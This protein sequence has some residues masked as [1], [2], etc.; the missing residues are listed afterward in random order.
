MYAKRTNT[1]RYNE[2]KMND[3]NLIFKDLLNK[4][5]T[6]TEQVIQYFTDNNIVVSK[7]NLLEYLA[8]N[9]KGFY[10]LRD[11][12]ASIMAGISTM[13]SPKKLINLNSNIGE[14]LKYCSNIDSVEGVDSNADNVRLSKYFH[15]NLNFTLEDPL[16]YNTTNKFDSV[17]SYPLLGEHVVING[18]KEKSEELY[19]LKALELLEINGSAVIL[20][21]DSV[22]SIISYKHLRELILD[23]YGLKS[24]ISLPNGIFT[25]TSFPFSIIE[26]V[27][28][29]QT[30]THFYKYNSSIDLLSQINVK[31]SSFS[32][33]SKNLTERW[34]YH[35]HN[36]LN[37]KYEKQLERFISKPIDELV[38][39]VKGVQISSSERLYSGDFQ[40]LSLSNISKGVLESTNKDVFINEDSLS[41]DQTKALLQNGDIVLQIITTTK[42][43]LYIHHGLSD[44]YLANSG[45]VILRGKN[46]EYVASYLNTKDGRELF[47]QQVNRHVRGININISDLRKILIPI[48][49][50]I[51]LELASE[52]KLKKLAFSELLEVKKKYD[53]LK[54]KFIVFEKKN[55]E[56]KSHKAQF[57]EINSKLDAAL[58]NQEIMTNKLDNIHNSIQLLS[59][60]FKAIKQIPR[61]IEEKMFR[62]QESLDKNFSILLNDNKIISDYI[63]E[64]KRWFDFYDLLEMKSQKYLPEA[65]FFLDHISKLEN[66]DYSPFVIQY[67]R[68]FENELLKKIFRA[69][70]QS[71]IDR[72]IDIESAF[73]W[74]LG[75][76]ESGKHN[77]LNTFNLAKNLKRCTTKD[78]EQWF[79]EL[80]TMEVNLRYLTGRSIHKSPL[81]QDLKAFLLSQFEDKVLNIEYLDE[82]K[83]IIK[84]YRNQSAH[85]NIIDAEM[86]KEF[87]GLIKECLVYLM[88]NYKH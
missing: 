7:E 36:P 71:L 12:I 67:C 64:I 47:D 8:S 18:K 55:V 6:D 43:N 51:D 27:S 70:V 53:S 79:F 3:S 32:V 22:L 4:G 82:I 75:R 83:R 62:F 78:S 52:R 81:L 49:P 26:I 63:H 28:Q 24:V 86:A 37:K 50:N 61:I 2:I 30:E 68:A 35:F 31:E 20:I 56:I 57:D 59:D 42:I 21:P 76:K 85:P 72:E 41:K 40:I 80:G 88:D 58:K 33:P 29:A 77:N 65:E 84:D 38:E 25:N 44:K 13:N 23:D 14:I 48:L 1:F 69:Y 54:S 66:P 17:V 46:A 15:P 9:K 60:D 11:E 10:Y 87:H 39:I 34:D 45:L 74:D 16:K 19:I 73:E 5:I